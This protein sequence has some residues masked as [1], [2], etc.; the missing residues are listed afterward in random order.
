M[1]EPAKVKNAG[2]PQQVKKAKQDLRRERIL[3]L[4]DL[5]AVLNAEQGRRVVARILS[6][7]GIFE[8]IY[9]PG[10]LIYFNSGKQDVG[11]FVLAELTEA[12]ADALMLIMRDRKAQ[13]DPEDDTI[14]PEGE[15]EDNA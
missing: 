13:V 12:R 15:A 3:E 9:A 10:D 5:R 14:K 4:E 8:S 6:F 11:N 7:C 1:V 2:D